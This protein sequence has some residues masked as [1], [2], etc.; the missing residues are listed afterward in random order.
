MRPRRG[1]PDTGR[2]HQLA[3]RSGQ[4]AGEGVGHEALI[5]HLE[6]QIEKLK[7][8]LYG[9]RSERTAR[10]IEQLELEL[11]ELV[12]TASEDELQAASRRNPMQDAAR[13]AMMP[14][15]RTSARNSGKVVSMPS[16]TI[17]SRA[18]RVPALLVGQCGDR[19][20]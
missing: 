9:P 12:T 1:H 7:R 2:S 14:G 6:L 15:S 10:L 8:E 5:A 17:S 11:E 20:G 19:F 18:R 16:T 4:R 3:S 13:E